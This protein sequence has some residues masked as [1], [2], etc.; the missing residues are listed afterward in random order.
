MAVDLFLRIDDVKGESR[1]RTHVGEIEALAWSFGASN[2]GSPHTGGGA[3][4]GRV[5]LQNL[6]ITKYVDKSSPVL[7]LACC[8]GKH[9]RSARLTVRKAGEHQLEFL[10]IELTEVTVSS[11]SAAGSSGDDRPSESLS[12]DFAK[13]KYSYTPQKVDGS[14]DVAVSMGWDVVANASL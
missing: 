8:T 11:I 3:G 13:L 6:S 5:S 14:A 12:L 4:V 7:L 9:H 10:V 1:D 2:S